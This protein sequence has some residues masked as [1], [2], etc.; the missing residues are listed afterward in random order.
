MSSR[1]QRRW[2]PRLDSRDHLPAEQGAPAAELA[3]LAGL[4]RERLGLYNEPHNFD[5]APEKDLFLQMSDAI[6]LQPGQV[7]DFFLTGK[8]PSELTGLLGGLVW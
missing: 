4:Q 5:C 6:N 7:E 8:L 2:H 1:S 3:G